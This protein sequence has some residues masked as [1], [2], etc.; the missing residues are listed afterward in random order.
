V[1]VGADLVAL[2]LLEIV[3]LGATSLYVSCG[4]QAVWS[5]LQGR[6]RPVLHGGELREEVYLEETSTLAGVT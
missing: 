4:K 2:T 3:A 1:Q 6:A 5:G